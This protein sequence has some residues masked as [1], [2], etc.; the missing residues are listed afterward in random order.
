[1]MIL[2]IM[3][4]ATIVGVLMVSI[5][6]LSLAVPVKLVGMLPLVGLALLVALDTT[7]QLAGLMV[8]T[9]GIVQHAL[10]VL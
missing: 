9:L 2:L 6:Q 4:V 1:M 10:P 8:V 7:T 5:K 3:A